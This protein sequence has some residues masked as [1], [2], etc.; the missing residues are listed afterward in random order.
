[1]FYIV[2]L[3]QNQIKSYQWTKAQII[4]GRSVLR[5]EWKISQASLFL[6]TQFIESA[7]EKVHHYPQLLQNLQQPVMR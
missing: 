2:Y 6:I 5:N 1:M 7:D 3:L 4:N